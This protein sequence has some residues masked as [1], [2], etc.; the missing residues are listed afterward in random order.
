MSCNFIF[1]FLEPRAAGMVLLLKWVTLLRV[2]QL[3]HEGRKTRMMKESSQGVRQ[4]FS[5]Q[6]C[7]SVCVKG[8]HCLQLSCFANC[9]TLLDD[10]TL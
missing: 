5:C 10:G 7:L 1:G 6:S 9:R 3:S 8:L 2:Y 4:E